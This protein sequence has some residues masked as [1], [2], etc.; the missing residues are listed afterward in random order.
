MILAAAG[1]YS[2]IANEVSVRKREIGIRM[3][4]G[5]T[6]SDVVRLF[7]MRALKLGAIGLGI[8]LLLAFVITRLMSNSLFGI[9]TL[10]P[11]TFLAFVI[12]LAAIAVLGAYI[13]ARR[14]ARVDPII[15]L[16]YE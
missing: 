5:A 16:R 10:D 3:A 9:V 2:L 15:V 12:V 13:P 14:A 6:P 4:M 8:G 1:G 11:F 7:V